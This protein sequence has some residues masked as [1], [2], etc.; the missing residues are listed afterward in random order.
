[1]RVTDGQ[2]LPNRIQTKFYL[3][4]QSPNLDCPRKSTWA[5]TFTEVS[6]YSYS[7]PS[8]RARPLSVVG[9]RDVNRK[10]EIFYRASSK[11]H[12]THLRV[13]NN[14]RNISYIAYGHDYTSLLARPFS[15]ISC[16]SIA[17]FF[18][19]LRCAKVAE[20]DKTRHVDLTPS[21][22]QSCSSAD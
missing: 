2:H 6:S 22:F 4:D 19:I 3:C 5:A 13:K 9:Q 21:V 10:F 7:R 11:C 18:Q 15:S 1:M 17:R 20:R 16:S 12:A 8:R 14:R